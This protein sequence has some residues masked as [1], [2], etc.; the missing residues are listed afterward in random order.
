[1]TQSRKQPRKGETRVAGLGSDGDLWGV[2]SLH[3]GTDGYRKKPCPECPWRKDAEVGRFPPEAFR[4]SANTSYDMA[5]RMFACHMSGAEKP[6]TCAGFLLRNADHNMGA[7]LAMMSGRID[8]TQITD[9]GVDLYESYRAM[10]VAN[11]VD[12]DDPVLDQSRANDE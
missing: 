9:D 3:G 11:G 7:R 2:T 5:G 8:P 1:M 4:Q 12:P 6:A 10:A